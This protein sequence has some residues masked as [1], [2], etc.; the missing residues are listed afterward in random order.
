[1]KYL[2]LMSLFSAP[3]FAD[4]AT[5]VFPKTEGAGTGFAEIVAPTPQ[6]AAQQRILNSPGNNLSGSEISTGSSSLSTGGVG[7]GVPEAGYQRGSTVTG[8]AP[9]SVPSGFGSP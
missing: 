6:S 8:S 1:M 5:F 7:S 4:D 9:S 2:V 3:A